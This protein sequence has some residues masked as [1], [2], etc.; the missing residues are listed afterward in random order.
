M[1]ALRFVRGEDSTADSDVRTLSDA[2]L[3]AAIKEGERARCH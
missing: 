1:E 3:E 2:D